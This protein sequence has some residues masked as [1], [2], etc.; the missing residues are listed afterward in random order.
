MKLPLLLGALLLSSSPVLADDLVYLKC[1]GTVQWGEIKP[2]GEKSQ[3]T[4]PITLHFKIDTK[5]KFYIDS[6]MPENQHEV[7]IRNGVLFEQFTDF[8]EPFTGITNAQIAFDPPGMMLA[9]TKARNNSTS[10]VI[11]QE[12]SGSCEA[13]D[14]E[15]YEASK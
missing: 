11:T 8:Q 1:T 7:K 14:A 2:S 4:V 9:K 3:E 12:I 15:T 6:V 10:V 13:S 5:E